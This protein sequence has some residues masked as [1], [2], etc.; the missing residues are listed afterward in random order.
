MTEHEGRTEAAA[1]DD[2]VGRAD[3]DEL[4]Q[5]M[6]AWVPAAITFGSKRLIVALVRRGRDRVSR[7]QYLLNKLSGLLTTLMISLFLSFALEPAVGYLASKG[8]RRGWATGVLFL[9]LLAS[10]VLIVALIVPAIVSGFN[11]L[12]D[13]APELVARLARWLDVFGIKISQDEVVSQI[14]TNAKDV[15]KYAANI[16]GGLAGVHLLARGGALPV[17]DD[18]AVHVL[19]RG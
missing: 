11:Q 3:A 9:A 18:R 1:T 12:V 16:A 14:Q 13:N 10:F 19:P 7:G 8:W 2:T 6:P 5:E 4:H 17:G 15:G